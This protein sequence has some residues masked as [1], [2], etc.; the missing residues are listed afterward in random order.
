M[1]VLQTFTEV[2]MGGGGGECPELKKRKRG[3]HG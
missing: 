3:T 1:L 2:L